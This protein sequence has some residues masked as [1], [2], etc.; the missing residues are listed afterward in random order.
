M[1]AHVGHRE[2]PAIVDSP[3]ALD[4]AVLRVW[5]PTEAQA[6]AGNYKMAHAVIGGL[7][8]TIET[9]FDRVRSGIGADGVPWS[10]RM[11]AHYGFVKRTRGADGDHVDVYVGPEAHRAHLL[12]VWIVDQ[13]DADTRAYDEHKCMIG[14]ADVR[15]AK[16]A[17]HGAFSDGR[18]QERV[19]AVAMMAFGDFVEW[20]KTGDTKA[21]LIMKSACAAVVV[22]SYGAATCTC[23][24]PCACR[25]STG[26]QM[27]DVKIAAKDGVSQIGVQAML[28]AKGLA[29]LTASQRAE[30]LAGAS[31]EVEAALAKAS[32]I[33]TEPGHEHDRVHTVTDLWDGNPDDRLRITH[34][35]GPESSAPPGDVNLGPSQ[36]A[37][38]NGADKMVREYSRPAPQEGV[39]RATD[40]LG[41]E[42]MATR[43]AMKSGMSALVSAI[44]AQGIV[45]EA[46]KSGMSLPAAGVAM[47]K[48]AV[49]AMAKSIV[50]AVVATAKARPFVLVKAKDE[51]DDEEDDDKPVAKADEDDEVEDDEADEEEKM[52]SKASEDEE[53]A[54]DKDDDKESGKSHAASLLLQM[55]KSRAR[56]AGRRIAKAEEAF[57][58][59]KEKKA[60]KLHK[61]AKSNLRIAEAYL[62]AAK[63]LRGGKVGSIARMIAGTVA[64]AKTKWADNQ[65]KWPNKGGITAVRK[66][67]PVVAA[68]TEAVKAPVDAVAMQAFTDATAQLSKAL[69]GL[70]MYQTDIKSMIDTVRGQPMGAANPMG[71]TVPALAKANIDQISVMESRVQKLVDDNVIDLDTFDK[72]RDV[73]GLARSK[74]DPEYINA[75]I[76]RLPKEV[77][78]VL[79]VAA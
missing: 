3:G 21:P 60:K 30:I 33:M 41:R 76:S 26:G 63:S 6:A 47:D 12:P 69:S 7:D 4:R 31:M 1:S 17:Y 61:M 23:E 53:E 2:N 58:D 68:A 62:E 66:S 10:V 55:A 44:R 38:G 27:T 20:L 51:D 11:P 40:M 59:D 64:K 45:I 56:F 36:A 9:P 79:Q 39:Q 75:R 46:M 25:G 42:L 77:R 13:C 73:I 5:Q 67:D 29:T 32:E 78:D 19:G 35:H 50:A 18:G 71:G 49:E 54:D 15:Q 74:A 24:G 34:A 22:P 65:T 14:F 16:D 57:D 48:T 43:V 8:V 70:G 28:M 37:S 52:V 72:T